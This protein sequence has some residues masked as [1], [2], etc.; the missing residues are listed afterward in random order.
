MSLISVNLSESLKLASKLQNPELLIYKRR[1]ETSREII[2]IFADIDRYLKLLKG[3]TIFVLWIKR[4]LIC[5]DMIHAIHDWSCLDW[6]MY[7]VTLILGRWKDRAQCNVFMCR[8]FRYQ[9]FKMIRYTSQKMK[10]SVKDFFFKCDQIH[11][12]L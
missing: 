3:K 8:I 12:R 7:D 9:W 2:N 4:D 11:R 6:P 1:L 5:N 10:F